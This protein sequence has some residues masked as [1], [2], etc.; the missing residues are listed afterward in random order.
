MFVRSASDAGF[1][2]REITH[3]RHMLR[4][5]FVIAI[6]FAQP[7]ARIVEFRQRNPDHAFDGAVPKVHDLD[8]AHWLVMGLPL[9]GS[10]NWL[11]ERPIPR[12]LRHSTDDEI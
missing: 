1:R 10:T 12:D 9:G 7:A 6:E 5:Q 2:D 8:L 3:D 11:T 4:P